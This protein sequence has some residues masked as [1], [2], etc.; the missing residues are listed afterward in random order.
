MKT[1][2]LEDFLMVYSVITP[3][4][5]VANYHSDKLMFILTVFVVG[6][7]VSAVIFKVSMMLHSLVSQVCVCAVPL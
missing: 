3:K 2:Y 6:P 7:V 4:A 1:P 5:G